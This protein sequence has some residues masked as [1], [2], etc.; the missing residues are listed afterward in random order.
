MRLPTVPGGTTGPHPLPEQLRGDEISRE[1]D[2]SKN[3]A[4][5]LFFEL[6]GG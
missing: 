1:G 6:T 5:D 2:E 3:I 4:P